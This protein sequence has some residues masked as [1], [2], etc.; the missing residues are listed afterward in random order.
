MLLG[1]VIE[2]RIFDMHSLLGVGDA[3]LC[4]LW[5]ARTNLRTDFR[6]RV[7]IWARQTGAA[8]QRRDHTIQLPNALVELLRRASLVG[9]L[10]R[11]RAC[12]VADQASLCTT[13]TGSEPVTS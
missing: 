3:V 12:I 5:K 4:I 1:N 6:A 7:G 9:L 8:F 13:A 11:W 10:R 2:A